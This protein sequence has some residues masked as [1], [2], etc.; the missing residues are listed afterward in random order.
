MQVDG[1]KKTKRE[2]DFF[3]TFINAEH[4]AD[5]FK[6]KKVKFN[7]PE[8]VIPQSPFKVAFS[9]EVFILFLSFNY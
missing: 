9:P 4:V 2:V 8:N 1:A 7:V 3:D 5:T 6:G